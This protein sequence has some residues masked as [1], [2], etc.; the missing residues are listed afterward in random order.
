M[1]IAKL[2]KKRMRGK[3]P[4][5]QQNQDRFDHDGLW[6]DLIDRFFW[7]LL[8]MVLPELYKDADT[9]KNYTFLDK[10]FRDV[11]NTADPQI[12]TSPHFAD[13]VID[14]PLKNGASEVVILHVEVQGQGGGDLSVRMYHYKCLIF[15]HYGRDPIALAI[16]TDKRPENETPHY[17]CS[18]YGTKSFY[19]YNRLVLADF[20]G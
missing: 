5:A 2:R 19:G 3:K 18:R 14:V 12:H 6:K 1:L 10:E 15:A 11:L 7:Y 9:N 20:G 8:E 16:I 13:Y 17:S 4:S